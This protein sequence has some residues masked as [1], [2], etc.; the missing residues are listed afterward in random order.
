MT[1]STRH[2]AFAA[3]LIAAVSFGSACATNTAPA[4]RVTPPT[5]TSAAHTQS[6]TSAPRVP[7]PTSLAPA[8]T[9]VAAPEPYAP[10]QPVAPA[11]LP[12]T[13][14]APAPEVYYPNCAAARAAHAAPIYRGEPGYR[15]GLDR[16]N[17]GIA[18]E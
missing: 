12:V 3:T 18:C 11:P 17:D 1:I 16:D 4:P 15:P 8:P 10:Q 7:I 5:T 2:F 13:T 9:T 6:A 14:Q